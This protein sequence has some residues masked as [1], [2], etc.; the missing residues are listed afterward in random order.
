MVGSQTDQPQIEL[1]SVRKASAGKLSHSLV[2]RLSIG[3]KKMRQLLGEPYQICLI[4]RGV[5]RMATRDPPWFRKNTLYSSWKTCRRDEPKKNSSL[6][7]QHKERAY[8]TPTSQT[9]RNLDENLS[10][11]KRL[12]SLL[13]SAVLSRGQ[14]S[15]GLFILQITDTHVAH[16]AECQNYN[17]LFLLWEKL[18]DGIGSWITFFVL[19]TC[20]SFW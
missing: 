4:G 17:S 12:H 2:W 19:F 1:H 6:R 3:P 9:N 8:L 20:F 5:C 13:I 15:L 18:K 7:W 10:R 16:R 11:S 14:K